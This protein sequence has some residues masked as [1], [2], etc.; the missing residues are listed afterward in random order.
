ME[1]KTKCPDGMITEKSNATVPCERIW[2]WSDCFL[3]P[4]GSYSKLFIFAAYQHTLKLVK[5]ITCPLSSQKI[6]NLSGEIGLDLRNEKQGCGK[7]GWGEMRDR[8]Q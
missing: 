7:G 5:T 8:D 2:L 4:S 6:A 1:G 3:V